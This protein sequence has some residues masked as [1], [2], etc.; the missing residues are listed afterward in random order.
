[1]GGGVA[2]S[3]IKHADAVEGLQPQQ[4]EWVALMSN[5]WK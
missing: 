2:L 4:D 3:K 5:V 1:L